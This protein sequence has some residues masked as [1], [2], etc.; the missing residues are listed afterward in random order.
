MKCKNPAKCLQPAS[1]FFSCPS[2]RTM[3]DHA[4]IQNR[5]KY[6][7]RQ[8]TTGWPLCERM[9]EMMIVQYSQCLWFEGCNVGFITFLKPISVMAVNDW[10]P[11]PFSKMSTN[12][13]WTLSNT[14]ISLESAS[15]FE[16][17]CFYTRSMQQISNRN[18]DV[19]F[20]SILCCL[21]THDFSFVKGL[22]F[23]SEPYYR[24][25]RLMQILQL[26]VR[27]EL[28]TFKTFFA[29][30]RFFL[31]PISPEF[32]QLGEIQ[33]NWANL[34]TLADVAL[35]SFLVDFAVSHWDS[36]GEDGSEHFSGHKS[37]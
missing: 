13:L 20:A 33:W 16:S 28:S 23:Q 2:Q 3:M 7:G 12:A 17:T 27:C 4:S 14:L 15:G 5:C 32:C 26:F 6:Q 18:S 35:H 30:L 36:T 25:T 31:H 37:R 1:V 8:C 11:A 34:V 19:P 24:M 10:V 22:I 29:E 21:T 9:R